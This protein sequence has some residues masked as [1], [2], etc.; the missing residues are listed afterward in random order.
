MDW[1]SPT[2]LFEVKRAIYVPSLLNLI[3]NIANIKL[4]TYLQN[5]QLQ[6]KWNGRKSQWYY[7]KNTILIEKYPSYTSMNRVLIQFLVFYNCIEDMVH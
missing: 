4:I 2:L 6:N 1:S 3:K 5:K 7:K